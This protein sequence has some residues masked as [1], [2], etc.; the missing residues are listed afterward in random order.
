MNKDELRINLTALIDRFADTATEKLDQI[1][2]RGNLTS[3]LAED[4]ER[5]LNLGVSVLE[6]AEANAHPNGPGTN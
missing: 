4:F 6:A 2:E 3:T 5:V 1:H